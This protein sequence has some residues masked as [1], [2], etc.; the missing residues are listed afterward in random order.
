MRSLSAEPEQ[1][2]LRHLYDHSSRKRDLPPF[3]PSILDP[4]VVLNRA[5]VVYNAAATV[6][7]SMA[8]LR[9]QA[10]ARPMALSSE[11]DSQL[12][13]IIVEVGNVSKPMLAQDATRE[14]IGF[15]RAPDELTPSALDICIG[16]T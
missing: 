5:P 1:K 2:I 4:V 11:S 13:R 6:H 15:Y 9:N 3:P 14:E 16:R 10:R 7:V 8:G 12:Y